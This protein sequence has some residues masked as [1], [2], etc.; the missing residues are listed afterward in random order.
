MHSKPGKN[1]EADKANEN[2][3]ILTTPNFKESST[4]PKTPV[5]SPSPNN[6]E[7]YSIFDKRQTA[8]IVTLVSVAA[9][10]KYSVIPNS[11]ILLT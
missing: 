7:P 6:G 4:R 9:T 3:P 2:P 8:L 5:S 1:L 10:C 11:T